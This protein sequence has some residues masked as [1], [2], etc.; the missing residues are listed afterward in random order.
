MKKYGLLALGVAV[1]TCAIV[2]AAFAANTYTV[3][4]ASVSPTKA[5]TSSKPKDK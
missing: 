2:G 4:V 3:T 1:A 5:G